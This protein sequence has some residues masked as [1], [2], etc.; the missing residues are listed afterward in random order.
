MVTAGILPFRENSDGRAG[1][2]TRDLMIIRQRLWPLDHE[3]GPFAFVWWCIF[4]TTH[5]CLEK[6]SISKIVPISLSISWFFRSVSNSATFVLPYPCFTWMYSSHQLFLTSLCFRL[7]SFT[8]GLH[9]LGCLGGWIEPHQNLAYVLVNRLLFFQ[10]FYYFKPF[11][12]THY[13][14]GSCGGTAPFFMCLHT[15]LE[16]WEVCHGHEN[17]IFHVHLRIGV[18]GSAVGWGTALQASRS[19]VWFPMVWLEFFIQIILLA[20]LWP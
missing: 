16:M 5:S 8:F 7:L 11:W 3:A 4:L 2:R 9:N 18:R 13:S 20:A 15:W 12:S 6:P 10:M 19:R 14:R 17:F 1:N